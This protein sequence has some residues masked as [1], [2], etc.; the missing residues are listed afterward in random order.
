MITTAVTYGVIALLFAG[1]LRIVY[2]AWAGDFKGDAKAD[3]LGAFILLMLT[4]W[5]VAWVAGV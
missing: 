5:F 1:C 3:A 2:K 4:A